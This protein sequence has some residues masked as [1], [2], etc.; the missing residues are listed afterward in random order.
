VFPKPA[1]QYKNLDK[2]KV[3]LSNLEIEPHILSA[4]FT[5]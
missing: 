1:P 3:C 2:F 5:V 4:K